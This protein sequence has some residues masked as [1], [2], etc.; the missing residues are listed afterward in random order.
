MIRGQLA[1]LPQRPGPH[2]SSGTAA[3]DG[4]LGV[5]CHSHLS[6]TLGTISPGAYR[7]LGCPQVEEPGG[8]APRTS[9]LS[10]SPA[11]VPVPTRCR[12]SHLPPQPCSLP[13]APSSGVPGVGHFPFH[14]AVSQ[15]SRTS[16]ALKGTPDTPGSQTCSFSILTIPATGTPCAPT[17]S[18]GVILDSF[19]PLH[20][21]RIRHQI[22]LTS[23]SKPFPPPSSLPHIQCY[24]TLQK[25][26]LL[27]QMPPNGSPASMLTYHT[28]KLRPH[29]SQ[30]HFLQK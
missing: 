7:H 16:C 18:R 22:L 30:Q 28:P 19:F 5:R 8:L 6:F 27:A 14:L 25:H 24:L 10:S 4:G 29:I 17:H 13:C 9:F 3:Q 1:P 15:P 20:P 11:A 2:C 21:H 12:H 26:H 23:P